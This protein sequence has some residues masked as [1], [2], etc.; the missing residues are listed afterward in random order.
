MR[1]F[2]L[3]LLGALGG[4][5]AAVY[6]ATRD[7]DVAVSVSPAPILL[8]PGDGSFTPPQRLPDL[9]MQIPPPAISPAFHDARSVDELID[10][11]PDAP[12]EPGDIPSDWRERMTVV[13]APGS[14]VDR[15]DYRPLRSS[16]W[17]V[18]EVMQANYPGVNNRPGRYDVDLGVWS[19]VE[20][21]PDMQG[22]GFLKARIIA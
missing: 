11:L 13:L 21:V 1:M 2:P 4:L 3:L 9:V 14:P 8:L 20:L 6:F 16:L 7:E 22:Q 18:K 5:G 19:A 17:I 10:L 12:G 15:D